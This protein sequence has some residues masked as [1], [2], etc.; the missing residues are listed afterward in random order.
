MYLRSGKLF[1]TFLKHILSLK[2]FSPSFQ[3]RLTPVTKI[4]VA[5]LMDLPGSLSK[6]IFFYIATGGCCGGCG[7]G[8]GPYTEKFNTNANAEKY[9]F[10]R[11]K[12]DDS[13]LEKF[14]TLGPKH[15]SR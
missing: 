8:S 12:C 4:N 10:D 15:C 13:E 9:D 2:H 6:I 7:S 3:H 14:I 11:L 5:L 1:E